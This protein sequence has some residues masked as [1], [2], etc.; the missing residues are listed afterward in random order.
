MTNASTPE[1]VSGPPGPAERLAGML[2]PEAIDGLLAD[3]EARYV[4]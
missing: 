1:P 3:A 2:S 4:G